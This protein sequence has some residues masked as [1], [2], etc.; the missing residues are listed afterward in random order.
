MRSG[1]RHDDSDHAHNHTHNNLQLR[2]LLLRGVLLAAFTVSILVLRV[3]IMKAELPV[4]TKCVCTSNSYFF[5]Y[6]YIQ[7]NLSDIRSLMRTVSE[8]PIVYF[9]VQINL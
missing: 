8:V 4:F 7:W 2:D 5:S 3:K 9:C 6:V 1:H